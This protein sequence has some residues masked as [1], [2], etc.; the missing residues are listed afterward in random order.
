MNRGR[1]KIL[2]GW[3]LSGA[4]LLAGVRSFA[5]ETVSSLLTDR[6]RPDG[7]VFEIVSD[8]DDLL[9]DLLPAL[10][11]DI[12]R[13]RKAWP[14]LPIAIVSHGREQFLLATK[15][16][17]EAE[18]AHSLVKQLM[19]E[20]KVDVH[21]CGTHAGWY[22]MAPEDFPDYVDVTTTGPAQ[23]NDYEEMGYTLIVL[24]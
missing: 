13:L 11:N 8:D 10:A 9:E 23:I 22:G 15:N 18:D 17:K 24:P 6:S 7:V 1:N 16:R 5:G 20:K 21:V 2:A 12:E 14:G 19:N 3:V 4:L